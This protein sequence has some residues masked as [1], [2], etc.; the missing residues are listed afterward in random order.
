MAKRKPTRK[1]TVQHNDAS[2][3]AELDALLAQIFGG[4]A[5]VEHDLLDER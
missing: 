1:T 4:D 2:D 5:D 3:T